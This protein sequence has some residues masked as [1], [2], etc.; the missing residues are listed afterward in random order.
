MWTPDIDKCL[1]QSYK[2]DGKSLKQCAEIIKTRYGVTFSP[3]AV[4]GRVHKLGI[5]KGK[6]TDQRFRRSSV[7]NL[8]VGEP[9]APYVPKA[10]ETPREPLR[11]T[12]MQL[13]ASECVWPVTKF[14]PHFFCGH[15][16]T[17]GSRYCETHHKAAHEGG[18]K[19]AKD[20][21]R[22]AGYYR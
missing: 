14:A 13:K 22:S 7:T 11:K 3:G 10:I 9:A 21:I 17:S 8:P 19:D 18:P 6:A 15:R 4:A 20:L 16:V 5:Q 1:R 12:L 2:V